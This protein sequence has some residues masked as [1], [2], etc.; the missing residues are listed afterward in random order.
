MKGTESARDRRTKMKILIV[1]IAGVSGG[2]KTTLATRLHNYLSDSRNANT[3]AA[4]NIKQVLLIQQD[5]YFYPRDSPHHIWIKDFNF[6][7]REL[8]SAIDTERL[9]S[10]IDATVSQVRNDD[11][12]S[13]DMCILLI[14]G[15]LIFND[16]RINDLCDVRFHLT[17]TAEVCLQRRLSRTWKH[18]NP[19]PIKYFNEYLWPSYHQHR[20]L[21]KKPEQIHFV[22]GENSMD[23]LFAETLQILAEH[24]ACIV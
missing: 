6:I 1:G 20:S 24:C 16:D 18:V 4:L 9:W 21:V 15:F 3:F 13:N 23:E 2:G 10:D 5:K 22:D 12:H 19:Q 14:E 11:H 8:L 17:L 7:N